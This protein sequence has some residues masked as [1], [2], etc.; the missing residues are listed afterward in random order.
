MDEEKPSLWTDKSNLSVVGFV[1]C[2]CVPWLPL[3]LQIVGVT[4]LGLFIQTS[5]VHKVCL[6]MTTLF[7]VI[8]VLD[9][10]Y[11]DHCNVLYVGLHLKNVWKLQGMIW[12]LNWNFWTYYQFLNRHNSWQFNILKFF[13][14]CYLSVLLLP[15]LVFYC[16]LFYSLLVSQKLGS[17]QK[18][19]FSARFSDV[20]ISILMFWF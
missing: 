4:R 5:T 1:Q 3:E 14:L 11:P 9:A 16:L 15:M 20:D 8:H 6:F 7:A 12:F 2:S 17:W 18:H 19:I 10:I 13:P